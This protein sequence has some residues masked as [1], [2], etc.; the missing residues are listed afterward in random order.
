MSFVNYGRHTA[1]FLLCFSGWLLLTALV[2]AD[3]CRAQTLALADRTLA[4]AK[5]VELQ[6][7]SQLRFLIDQK[8]IGLAYSDICRFNAHPIPQRFPMAILTDGSCLAVTSIERRKDQFVFQ[9]HTW[10]NVH[11]PESLLRAI[12]VSPAISLDAW[13]TTLERIYSAAG[14]NDQIL[15]ATRGWTDGILIWPDSS[16]EILQPDGLQKFRINNDDTEIPV[17]EVEAMIF[18][19]VLTPT[20]NFK[21][22]GRIG[23]NDG[24]LLAA[25]QWRIAQPGDYLELTLRCGIVLKSLDPP[26]LLT[27]KIVSITQSPKQTRYLSDLEASSYKH[28]DWLSPKWPLAKDRDL[29][30]RP[31]R[32]SSGI[33]EKGLA[34]H[35]TSQATFR[36]DK[37]PAQFISSIALAPPSEPG[38]PNP[39]QAIAKVMTMKAGKLET[40]YTSPIL[41]S[42]TQPQ[43]FSVSLEGV[44]LIVLIVDAGP[45]GTLGDH[46][47]WLDTRVHK[48]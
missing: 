36:W 12:V 30:G 6:D 37:S 39:G 17:R 44:E 34:M 28:V 40:M 20:S 9:S 5:I 8:T 1:L 24:S 15:L 46:V 3:C 41:S 16:D 35:A 2:P 11:V 29:S 43:D 27:Q 48:Q 47:L 38:L 33:I 31:L 22:A 14:R 7:N 25:S 4:N 23:W 26:V 42:K 45:N 13:Y 10:E 21:A 18:S 19:P 32:D